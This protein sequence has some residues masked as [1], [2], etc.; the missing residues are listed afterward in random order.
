MS[1]PSDSERPGVEPD[2]DG[3]LRI[4]AEQ[5]GVDFDAVVERAK[6]WSAENP[7]PDDLG[8]E[9]FNVGKPRAPID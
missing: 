1:A 6:K 2:A 5:L 8:P 9:P 7:M 4:F 3:P